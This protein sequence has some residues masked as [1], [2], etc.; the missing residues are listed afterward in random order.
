[1]CDLSGVIS[2]PSRYQTAVAIGSGRLSGKFFPGGT[3][4][5][6]GGDARCLT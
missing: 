2:S 6:K 4:I 1:M 5:L 3:P